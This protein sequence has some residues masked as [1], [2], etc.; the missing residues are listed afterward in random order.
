MRT[1]LTLSDLSLTEM[2]SSKAALR[3]RFSLT[4]R[5][6]PDMAVLLAGLDRRQRSREEGRD[7]Y[8]FPR[9]PPSVVIQYGSRRP[10]PLISGEAISGRPQYSA[11]SSCPLL[12]QSIPWSREMQLTMPQG[13]SAEPP[14]SAT[15]GGTTAGDA[16]GFALLSKASARRASII[17]RLSSITKL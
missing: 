10:S 1:G 3:A 14:T 13:G 4:L 5:T 6:I 12:C 16:G 7:A 2:G 9:M 11:L 15:A 8:A 17:R